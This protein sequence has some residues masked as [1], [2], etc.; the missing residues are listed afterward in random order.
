MASHILAQVHAGAPGCAQQLPLSSVALR[1][2]VHVHACHVQQHAALALENPLRLAP[3]SD[4]RS[5]TS[6][7]CS[8]EGVAVLGSV[9]EAGRARRGALERQHRR[10]HA[11]AGPCGRRGTAIWTA[12]ARVEGQLEIDAVF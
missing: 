4:T 5:T 11:M 10:G 3:V 6:S 8:P 7:P 9:E 12:T 2:M 1:R